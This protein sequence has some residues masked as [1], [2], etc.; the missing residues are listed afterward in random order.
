MLIPLVTA[1][2]FGLSALG[3][4]LALIIMADS[5]GQTFGPVLAGRI[6]DTRHSYDL[7]WLIITAAGILG[8]I[9]IYF[10]SARRITHN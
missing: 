6:Y 3:K 4:I 7:V 10:I 1:H 5:L 8:A 9:L 2:N